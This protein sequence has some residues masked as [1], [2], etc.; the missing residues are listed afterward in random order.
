MAISVTPTF[1]GTIKMLTGKFVNRVMLAVTGLVDSATAAGLTITT[2]ASVGGA[3]TGGTIDVA[4]SGYAV[5]Q[6]VLVAGGVGGF[7]IV[8]GTTT[9]TS[10]VPSTIAL[11][12]SGGTGYTGS[13][14]ASTTS[15][16][17]VP[18][19]LPTTPQIANLVPGGPTAWGMPTPPDATNVYV[20]VASGGATAGTINVEYGRP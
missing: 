4:G 17:S 10:G 9:P 16:N 8:T 3:L 18:H 11:Y 20:E 13:T 2:T 15:I 6:L 19:G 7:F 1:L 14:G 12:G 5:G